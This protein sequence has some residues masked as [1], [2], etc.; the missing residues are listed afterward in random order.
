[1]KSKMNIKGIIII[2]VTTMVSMFFI[3]MSFAANTGKVNVETANLR[4]EPNADSIILEQL[5]INQEVEILEKSGEWYQVKYN[6]I[7][8]FLRQDLVIVS[9]EASNTTTDTNQVNTVAEN[10]AVD[11]NTTIQNTATEEQPKEGIQKG[12]YVVSEDTK[13]KIVPSI[14]A[15]DIIEVKKEEEVN[16]TE[17]MNGWACIETMTTKGWIREEKLKSKETV[18][19]EKKEEQ[20]VP[21]E[22][23][24]TVAQET[25]LKTQYVKSASVNLRAEPNT[26]AAVVTTLTVNTSVDV[27]E[28]K[29]GWSK[30]KIKSLAKEG[31]ISTAL[32]SDTKQETSRGAEATRN[33]TQKPTTPVVNETTTTTTTSGGGTS[34]VSKAKQYIGSRYVYGGSS[35]SGFDCSGFTSYVY[36]Q[37]GVS[38]NRTAAGQYSNGTAVSK[39]QLQPGD[40]VMFGK[41]GINHV[42]I[43]IGGGQ[44]VHAANPSRGVTTDTINS[45]YYANNYV[46][47][48]R[49]M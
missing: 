9:G 1:M 30:V 14:N 35:P 28:E 15:T 2:A 41:S 4:K 49:V 13:L 7:T 22:E 48:R 45:G 5:S 40:L 38:L 26:S 47:A 32:L 27:Y 16:V 33:K 3:N 20:N 39:S 11:T 12:T 10:T 34:V 19:Q 6:N 37:F 8:G 36:K 23:E 46:G 18:E 21:T 25:V 31:Y 43:Y 17:V 24:K 44:M 42:G 29:D